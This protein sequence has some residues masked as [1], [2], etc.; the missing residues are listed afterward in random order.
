MNNSNNK[1]KK[2]IPWFL[3]AILLIAIAI[4]T[5]L[6]ISYFNKF[7]LIIYILLILAFLIL[8]IDIIL[9]RLVKEKKAVIEPTKASDTTDNAEFL[10]IPLGT[11]EIPN[12]YHMNDLI[13]KEVLMHNEV[14]KIGNSAFKYCSYLTTITISSNLTHIGLSAFSNCHSLKSIYIPKGVTYIGNWAFD[15]CP[16]LV[17]FCEAKESSPD[18]AE[19]WNSSNC[20]VV[21]DMSLEDYQKNNN[22]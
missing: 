20:P 2:I 15:K 17:I 13:V 21:W 4:S 14:E 6:L 7:I 19:H 10:E 5:H 3:T 1:I 11:I 16:N 22:L 9:D 12:S 18:W 8:I